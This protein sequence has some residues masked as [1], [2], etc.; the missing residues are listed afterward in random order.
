MHT[1]TVSNLPVAL[2]TG[3]NSGLGLA[4]A[5]KMAATHR[6]FATIR[7][8]TDTKRSALDKAAKEA[9]VEK[10]VEVIEMDVADDESVAN[11]VSE[12]LKKTDGR[13]DV[14]V[15]NA[16]FSVFGNVEMVPIET[17]KKQFETNVF[18]VV[19]TQQ[20]ILPAMRAQKSGKIINISS[21]GGVWGQP[22]N[23]VYCAS[24]FALEGMSEAQAAVFRTF[25]VY[26]T[27]VQPGAIRS[28]FITNAA[29]P[30]MTKI[31]AEYVK[32]LQSTVASFQN[33]AASASASQSPEEV[34]QSII[35]Q[36]IK[37][38]NPPLKVQTNPGIAKVFEGQLMDTTGEWG[39][40]TAHDRFIA[41]ETAAK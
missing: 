7:G 33:T 19:R 27:N 12:I 36:V 25:G 14:L 41:G 24:K 21:V 8:L 5:V 22:F 30:D 9:N 11:T 26:V 32:P 29:R 39:V 20:A 40:Q 31:P 2:I 16:G 28:K 15:N 18:G 38:E 17:V 3:T 6:V 1:M 4:L 23:D 35:D 34:A 37:V 13:C 10:N